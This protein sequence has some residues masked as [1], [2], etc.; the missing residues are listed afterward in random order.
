MRLSGFSLLQRGTCLHQIESVDHYYKR[1]REFIR[2]SA[3][4]I[5]TKGYVTS[6]EC[7]R[8]SLLEMGTWIHQIEL[9]IFTNR[10]LN[11]SDY[12]VVHYYKGERD[13]FRLS[14]LLIITNGYVTSTIFLFHYYK[15]ECD[16]I[17]LSALYIITLGNLTW[18]DCLRCS[19]LH[20]GTWPDQIVCVVYYYKG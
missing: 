17:R 6:S 8:C 14:A 13:L 7:L 20:W 16:F 1:E 19:L 2:F 12:I 10:E 3:L 5:I 15:G 18:S 11:S 9:F 4:F